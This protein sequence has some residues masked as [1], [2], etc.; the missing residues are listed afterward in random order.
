MRY[1]AQGLRD[2]LKT[3]QLNEEFFDCLDEFQKNFIEMC[4]KQ[5]YDEKMGLMTEVESY[6]FHVF[7]E[8][9]I[10]EFEQKYGL[11]EN[12]WKKVA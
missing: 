12:Y 1:Y 7:K 9:R 6:N 4:F 5:S 2:L 3:T 11:E 8:Y 10:R